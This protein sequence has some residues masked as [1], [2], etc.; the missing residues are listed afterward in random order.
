MNKLEKSH[1]INFYHSNLGEVCQINEHLSDVPC[2]QMSLEEF[3]SLSRMRARAHTHT[4]THTHRINRAMRFILQK[5][6][7]PG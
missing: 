6:K 2:I 1:K 7:I 5:Q 3:L 4:H